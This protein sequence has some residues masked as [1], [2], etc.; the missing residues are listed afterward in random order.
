[1][2]AI[3][4][5]IYLRGVF[6]MAGKSMMQGTIQRVIA[7]H[8]KQSDTI[9]D[10]LLMAMEAVGVE[11]VPHADCLTTRPFSL[12]CSLDTP[13]LWL[14]PFPEP[15]DGLLMA[16]HTLGV[17][18]A[19]RLVTMTPGEG[20]A[21]DVLDTV[22][23]WLQDG[24]VILGPLNRTRVWERIESR[25]YQGAAHFVL[26][27]RHGYGCRL[28]VHDPEG[29][30]YFPVSP[31]RLLTALETA[32]FEGGALQIQSMSELHSC[33]EVFRRAFLAGIRSCAIAA[34]HTEGGSNG[35]S[36]LAQE[37]AS[38]RLKSSEE[39]VLN[40][41]IP[42]LGLAKRQIYE[43]L[44]DM[45]DTVANSFPDWEKLI[46][47]VLA[48]LSEYCVDCANALEML[49]KRDKKGL[50]ARFVKMANNE[51]LLNELFSY[52]CSEYNADNRNF[53]QVVLDE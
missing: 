25:Y 3:T 44:F 29:C 46:P 47:H 27:V 39:G 4:I 12:R 26:V 19:C 28:V 13:S 50:S 35:L 5:G 33:D 20:L 6:R 15:W 30:P 38:R 37:I 31:K 52:L 9:A 22:K 34:V 51:E 2:E 7:Y 49:K 43:F 53:R 42:A 24:P 40:F 1:M 14:A 16:L 17:R 8:G 36:A 48:V 21:A 18:N 41:A 10:V 11:D 45:P 32:D 23:Q